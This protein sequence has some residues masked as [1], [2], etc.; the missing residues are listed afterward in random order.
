MQTPF[1]QFGSAVPAGSFPAPCLPA[2][3]LLRGKSGEKEKAL[4]LCKYCSAIAKTMVCYLTNPKYSPIWTALKKI[5]PIPARVGTTVFCSSTWFGL[6]TDLGISRVQTS[7][8]QN[9]WICGLKSMSAQS[10]RLLHQSVSHIY[11][12]VR[13]L[14]RSSSGIYMFLYLPTVDWNRLEALVRAIAFHSLWQFCCWWIYCIPLWIHLSYCSSW[15][16]WSLQM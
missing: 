11:E 10:C 16:A 5:N 9:G 3:Y 12:M 15:D 6:A 2:A 13:N 4:M 1:R 8:Y 14:V 7:M